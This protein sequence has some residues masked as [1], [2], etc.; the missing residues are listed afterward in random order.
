[1]SENLTEENPQAKSL[2]VRSSQGNHEERLPDFTYDEAVGVESGLGV[3]MIDGHVNPG[4]KS[5]SE[6]LR[7]RMSKAIRTYSIEKGDG[8]WEL[9][10]EIVHLKAGDKI[11]I[12]I[13]GTFYFIAGDRGM[14]LR[15]V[16]ALS[17][18]Y[19]Q[20]D[21]LYD[22]VKKCQINC[23]KMVKVGVYGD[24]LDKHAR[25]LLGKYTKYFVHSL[26]HGVGEK[27]HQKPRISS[28]KHDIVKKG[29]FITIEPGIY[30]K[31]NNKNRN[32]NIKNETKIRNK[33][34]NE[35]GIRI[36]DTIYVENETEILTKLPKDLICVDLKKRVKQL[37]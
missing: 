19:K 4:G 12:G 15:E 16:N 18:D 37:Q 34:K 35:I 10:G 26:G 22:L 24:H 1:M 21:K 23:C 7:K 17:P 2:I 20:G 30:I 31:T 33:N 32:K 36:E 3:T 8:D 9:N 11:V 25:K 14:E 13:G 27:I 5:Q 6:G 28:K 29:D